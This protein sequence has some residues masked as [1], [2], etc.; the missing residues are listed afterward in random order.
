M[1]IKSSIKLVLLI[2]SCTLLGCK[3]YQT[4]PNYSFKSIQTCPG[5][6]DMELFEFDNQFYILVSGAERRKE[7]K[8]SWFYLID[9]Q[10]DHARE[11]SIENLPDSIHL[12]LHG[13]TIEK[14][15]D[16]VYVYAI[17]HGPGE[18]W[19]Q[20]VRFIIKDLSLHFDQ[21]ITAPDF[22][23]NP[24]DL[25]VDCHGNIFVTNYLGKGKAIWQYLFNTKKSTVVKYSVDLKKWEFLVDKIAYANGVYVTDSILY[26]AT[27]RM[28][29]L[30]AFP[31]T[32]S[33]QK[34][35]C[36][37]REGDLIAA[38]KGLDNLLPFE[39][40]LYTTAHPSFIKFI[41]H[42]NTSEKKSPSQVWS[43]DL[44]THE[45]KLLYQDD[46]HTISAASTALR[47]R[48]KIYLGQ[49]FDSFVGVLSL[50]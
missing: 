41:G 38:I 22:L 6:E 24:N 32:E 35:I 1:T 43:I 14:I 17:D 10:T 21:V 11:L 19:H 16:I 47:F 8:D 29:G 27:T 33:S 48:N 40:K 5:T 39:D 23:I 28:K 15:K 44:K 45:K 2:F 34:K 49:I 20:I 30:Y 50:D 4:F 13:L 31:Q 7:K 9:T 3:T 26:V 46:G 36:K 12:D 42:V 18:N 37:G 25:D